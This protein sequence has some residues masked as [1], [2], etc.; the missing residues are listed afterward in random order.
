M[1]GKKTPSSKARVSTTKRTPK[2]TA[3][4]PDGLAKL[5]ANAE[6]RVAHQRATAAL[7]KVTEHAVDPVAAF[8]WFNLVEAMERRYDL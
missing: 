7:M 4:R 6:M 3:A 1:A 5:P 8:S 2:K